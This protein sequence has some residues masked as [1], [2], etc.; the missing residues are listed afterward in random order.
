MVR[1]RDAARPGG[2]FPILALGVFVGLATACTSIIGVTQITPAKSDGG[3]TGGGG[4]YGSA[5]PSPCPNAYYTCTEESVSSGAELSEQDSSTC[6]LTLDSSPAGYV[7]DTEFVI[8]VDGHTY[9]GNAGYGGTFTGDIAGSFTLCPSDGEPCGTCVLSGCFEDPSIACSEGT[10]GVTCG[11]GDSPSLSSCGAAMPEDDANLGYCC[12]TAAVQA[13]FDGGAGGDASFADVVAVGCGTSTSIDCTADG[14]TGYACNGGQTPTD[15]DSTLTCGPP[16]AG[17]NEGEEDFCCGEAAMTGSCPSPS[18]LCP[19]TGGTETVT[20]NGASGVI[21]PV[22]SDAGEDQCDFTLEGETLVLDSS[23]NVLV[24]GETAGT[25][26]SL[27]SGFGVTFTG[28][29]TPT[30]DCSSP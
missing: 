10:T 27:G 17:L 3:S 18:S 23:C 28:S 14:T 2:A 20:C 8:D 5:V 21:A 7:G 24:E 13:E 15:T 4:S 16:N 26:G 12:A 11:P 29:T 30:F 22:L 25:W 19:A 9:T 1:V 6:V